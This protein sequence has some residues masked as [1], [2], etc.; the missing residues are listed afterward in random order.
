M[1]IL[2]GKQVPE[3]VMALET[4][5]LD[6]PNATLAHLNLAFNKTTDAERAT[7]LVFSEP[8]ERPAD[9]C[10]VIYWAEV[11]MEPSSHRTPAFSY[12]LGRG[13]GW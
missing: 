10:A 8:E 1:E 4:N 6:D 9:S 13:H 5:S 3:W 11:K 7:R 12:G 2:E